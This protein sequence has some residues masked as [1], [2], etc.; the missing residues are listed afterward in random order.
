MHREESRLVM[1][2]AATILTLALSCSTAWAQATY[3][4]IFNFEQH[5]SDGYQPWSGVVLDARGN[6]FGNTEQGGR[7]GS[8]TVYQLFRNADGGWNY[9]ILHS[10]DYY[11]PG[12]SPVTP[13]VRDQVG[14][15]Y[16]IDTTEVFEVDPTAALSWHFTALHQ[17][18]GGADGDCQDLCSVS[19]D[20]MGHLYGSTLAGGA[21]GSGVV[22]MDGP[23][24]YSVLYNFTG[25][26]DGGYGMGQLAFDTQGNIYGT[27]RYGGAYGHGVAYRLSPNTDRPDW[28]YTILHDFKGTPDGFEAFAGLI[29]EKDGNLYGTTSAGGVGQQGTVFRLTPNSDGTWSESVIYSFQG[30]GDGAGPWAVPTMDA[31]G[32]LYGTTLSGGGPNNYGTVYKLTPS[33]NGEWSETVLHAFQ[34]GPYDGRL[35]FFVPVAID[36]ARN[37]YGT[38]AAG[39]LYNDGGV[40]WEITP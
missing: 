4:V 22:F 32:S 21:Y 12:N 16:G 1:K 17:F 19:M 6:I 24:G 13:M 36:S 25:G 15:L 7:Y 28:T 29:M 26:D 18:T 38:T 30:A 20:A 37:L 10:F 8:G 33:S 9:V 35:P 31:A 5:P 27:T 34:G 11:D 2:I 23:A 39:G 14:R 40:V 3:R